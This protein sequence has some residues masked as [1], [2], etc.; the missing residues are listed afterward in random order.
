MGKPRIRRK[1]PRPKPTALVPVGFAVPAEGAAFLKE[2]P[3]RTR[4]VQGLLDTAEAVFIGRALSSDKPSDRIGFYL[5]RICVED[6]NEILLLAGT[7]YGV[8]AQKVLRGMYERAVT[9]AYILANPE[10]AEPFWTCPH[11]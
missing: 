10:T 1:K 6:F 7:G 3:D 11:F 2:N 8:G 5:G 9:S 4:A